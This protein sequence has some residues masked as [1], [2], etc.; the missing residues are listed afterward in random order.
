MGREKAVKMVF[1]KIIRKKQY[2]MTDKMLLAE[3]LEHVLCLS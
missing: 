2:E 3:D 1:G